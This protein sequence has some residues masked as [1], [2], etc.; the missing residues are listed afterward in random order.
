LPF[1][2]VTFGPPSGQAR[3]HRVGLFGNMVRYQGHPIGYSIGARGYMRG[4]LCLQ[5]G[6]GINLTGEKTPD[7]FQRERGVGLDF[8]ERPFRGDFGHVEFL[9]AQARFDK[10]LAE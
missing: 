1:G 2:V 8:R 10:G 6:A 5:H 4:D 9:L 7:E 3:D